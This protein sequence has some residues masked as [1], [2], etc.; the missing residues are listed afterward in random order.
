MQFAFSD[1]QL[2]TPK[3]ESLICAS[4]WGRFEPVVYFNIKNRRTEGED[5]A[6]AFF[7]LV[8]D[9]LMLSTFTRDS[10]FLQA[11]GLLSR[12]ESSGLCQLPP[13]TFH[14]Q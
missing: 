7:R 5:S 6:V 3:R 13:D 1:A 9:Y 14:P 8:G 10:G 11:L 4:N 12:Q 2:K